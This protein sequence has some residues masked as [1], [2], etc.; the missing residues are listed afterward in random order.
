M[1]F[2]VVDIA[3][4]EAL[5]APQPVPTPEGSASR[6]AGRRCLARKALCWHEIRRDPADCPASMLTAWRA[7][8]FRYSGDELRL[9]AEFQQHLERIMGDQLTC[10]CRELSSLLLPDITGIRA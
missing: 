3:R 1:V 8:A 6:L 10:M 2:R 5:T 7:A 9:F 4:P